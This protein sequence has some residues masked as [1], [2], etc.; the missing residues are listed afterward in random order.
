MENW[1]QKI[2]LAQYMLLGTVLVT[3]LNIG[4]LLGNVDMYISYCAAGPYYLVWLG[5]LFDN[6]LAMGSLNGEFTATGLVMAGVLLAVFLLLW[7]LA[8]DSRKWLAVGLWAIVLDLALLVVLAFVLFADPVSVFWEAVL[9][10]VVI[11][12]IHQ[13][14]Q[15]Y[16]QR[17]T[18]LQDAPPRQQEDD[19]SPVG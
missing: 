14:L 6:N 17:D 3:L 13:G 16:K 12:E 2:K 18:A 7:W 19:Y 4:F 5:K 11:W 9:H 10:L 1:N 8:R 15:A